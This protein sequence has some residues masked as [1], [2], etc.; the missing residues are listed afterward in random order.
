[1][2]A[3]ASVGYNGGADAECGY[4]GS[5]DEVRGGRGSVRRGGGGARR[6][7]MVCYTV[8]SV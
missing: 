1:V 5:V 7:A 8:S 4:D 6:D 3:W 2:S